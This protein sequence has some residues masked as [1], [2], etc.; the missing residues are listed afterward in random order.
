[1][2]ILS[3]NK[4]RYRHDFV[5]LGLQPGYYRFE[6]FGCIFS[7]VVHKNNGTVLKSFMCCHGLNYVVCSIVLPV[8]GIYIP[9]YRIEV[10]TIDSINC[11]AG[12]TESLCIR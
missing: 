6:S 7:T 2:K 4:L 12:G 5:A 8:K 1:M 10:T 3:I 11:M 9:F